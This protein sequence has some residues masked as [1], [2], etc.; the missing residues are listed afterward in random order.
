MFLAADGHFLPADWAAIIF[1]PSFF[2]RLPHMVLASYLCVAFFVGAVGAFHLLRS[3]SNPAARTMFS[4]AMGMITVVAPLQL[5]SRR[6]SPM[7]GAA[8]CA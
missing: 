1:N 7:L 3:P 2:Y 4:M 8:T 5:A 6:V